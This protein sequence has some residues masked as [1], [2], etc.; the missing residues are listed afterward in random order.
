VGEE[1]RAAA[2]AHMG[3]CGRRAQAGGGASDGGASDARG[4]Q[5][6]RATAGAQR[7]EKAAP[8]RERNLRWRLM[9]EKASGMSAGEA[10]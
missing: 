3:L 2:G 9:R 6:A 10:R 4:P 8:E 5:R 1:L 7:R